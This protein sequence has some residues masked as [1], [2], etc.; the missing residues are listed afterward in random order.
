VFDPGNDPPIEGV[1]ITPNIVVPPCREF[2]AG[3][4]PQLAK[5]FELIA[6]IES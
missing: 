3:S 6:E 4:D 2:C 1:G 5:V